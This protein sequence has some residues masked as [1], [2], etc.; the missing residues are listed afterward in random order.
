MGR[1]RPAASTGEAAVKIEGGRMGEQGKRG[2]GKGQRPSPPYPFPFSP[3]PPFPP[4]RS[5]HRFKSEVQFNT[6]V[7][8]IDCV[9]CSAMLMRKR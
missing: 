5:R 8:G 6:I 2:S 3:V 9:L 4:I 7:K 1:D